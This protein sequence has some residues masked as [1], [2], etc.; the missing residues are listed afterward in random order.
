MRIA[1]DAHMVGTHETGNE[2]YILNLI[3]GLQVVDAKNS[4]V[5]L[6]D[7]ADR[8]REWVQPTDR[9][10]IVQVRPAQDYVRI[11]FGLPWTTWRQGVDVLHVTYNAPPWSSCP[12]VVSV[13]D[14]SFALY[15]DQ[16]SPRDRLILSTL[17]PLSMRRA[18]RVITLSNTARQDI[19]DRYHIPAGRVVTTPLA[20]ADVFRPVDDAGTLDAVLKR[21]AIPGP[22]ILAVG[23][24]QPR[25]NLARLLEAYT[26]VRATS[27]VGHKLVIVG[28]AQWQ[29]SQIFEAVRRLGLDHEVI[30]T[31][32]VPDEDLVRLYNAATV[33]VYPSLY[34]GFGL[35]PLEAMACGTPVIASNVG[36]IREVVADGG[37]L[38]SPTNV[39]ELAAALVRV[40]GEVGL[41]AELVE[42]GRQ[43]AKDFSW[44]RT[45]ETTLAVYETIA[46]T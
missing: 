26:R 6:T 22:F 41:R 45:A 3:R 21:Y 4:Y 14:V 43:R 31:G 28:K 37:L 13:H 9:F 32:Y 16:F 46:V 10:H 44:L 35:P 7:D 18:A 20:A 11:P 30:F 2:T 23:N 36:A 38:V 34:E 25:K 33:F 12:T 5:L 17:V 24:L 15:P 1:I 29:E 42:R 39:D 27:G 19:L 8:L 40:A